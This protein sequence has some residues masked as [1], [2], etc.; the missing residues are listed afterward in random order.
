MRRARLVSQ[1]LLGLA[2]CLWLGSIPLG[3]VNSR[4]VKGAFNAGAIA[5]VLIPLL[6]LAMGALI[7]VRQPSNK[8][9]WIFTGIGSWR[10]WAARWKSAPDPWAGR[11]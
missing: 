5:L 11:P 2:L 7:F 8:A 6:W 4:V 1:V 9:G 10:S 3:I